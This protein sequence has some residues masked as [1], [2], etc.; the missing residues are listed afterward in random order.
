MKQTVLIQGA[1]T[2][3]VYA[4]YINFPFLVKKIT[5]R[6]YA[7]KDS[8]GTKHITVNCQQMTS[9]PLLIGI[10]LTDLYSPL[11]VSNKFELMRPL[12]SGSYEFRFMTTANGLAT[13]ID[14][15]YMLLEFS[16]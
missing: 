13:T 14:L 15:I 4:Q 6:Q 3:G 8:T 7:L 11:T 2:N 12:H 5:V 9:D 16:D 1:P 10:S